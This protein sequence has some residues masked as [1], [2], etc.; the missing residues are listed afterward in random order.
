LAPTFLDIA[1]VN[2]P[3]H[4]DGRSAFKLFHKHKK[5]NK[6]FIAHWPD[7]FLIES[8]G[9]REHNKHKKNLTTLLLSP[10]SSTNGKLLLNRGDTET[11]IVFF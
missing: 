8:S 9:R 1:G 4:M 2:P 11:N 10:L 5:G 7:T 3:A 6:K